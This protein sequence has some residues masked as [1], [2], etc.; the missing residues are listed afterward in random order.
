MRGRG[1]LGWAAARTPP[2]P[3]YSRWSRLAQYSP[4]YSPSGFLS[5]PRRLAARCSPRPTRAWS[6]SGHCT[7]AARRARAEHPTPISRPKI[8]SLISTGQLATVSYH[9]HRSAVWGQL[10]DH[11]VGRAPYFGVERLALLALGPAKV[12]FR[13]AHVDLALSCSSTMWIPILAALL[14]CPPAL[15][16]FQPKNGLYCCVE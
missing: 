14:F 15:T 9:P 4:V 5:A 12:N 1:L 2:R 6:L 8:S 16:G 3:R 11:S 10:S 7:S 13:W